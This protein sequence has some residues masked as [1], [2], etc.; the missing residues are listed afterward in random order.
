M[1]L[2]QDLC[3]D[4][5]QEIQQVY[6]LLQLNEKTELDILRPTL[7]V[8]AAAA[9]LERIACEKRC[10]LLLSRLEAAIQSATLE[11][12]QKQVLSAYLQHLL[13]DE[14]EQ[15]QV[16]MAEE[17]HCLRELSEIKR[18]YYQEKHY[19]QQLDQ[20]RCVVG[21]DLGALVEDNQASLN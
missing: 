20:Q 12:G 17:S 7:S 16:L 1:A 21:Q 13:D 8:R 10:R 15:V 14:S 6:H 5:P 2:L 9:S 11:L 18:L 3:T 19:L 4:Y